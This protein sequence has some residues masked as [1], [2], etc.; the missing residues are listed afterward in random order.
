[1]QDLSNKIVHGL[2]PN[3]PVTIIGVK[4]LG[5]KISLRYTG[6]NSGKRSSKVLSPEEYERLEVITE[7]GEF[8]FKGNAEHFKLFVE[9]ERIHTAYQFDPLFA[10]NCSVVDPLPHQVEAVYQNLLP[11]PRIRFLLADDTGAGKTIMAGLLIKEL[12]IRSLVERILIITPGGLTKQWQQD[13]MQLKFNMSFR[14]VDRATFNSEPNIFTTADRLVTSID[15][16]RGEDVINVAKET[17]WDM[18]IVDEAHKLSAYNYGNRSYKSQRY[19]TIEALAGQCEHLLLLTATPHRGRKD[20]FKNLLQLLD[21]DIFASDVLVTDRINELSKTGANKFFIRRLKEEMKDWEGAPLFKKRYTKTTAYKLTTPEM[22]L[23]DAVTNYLTRRKEEADQNRNVH[24]TLTLMVMQRRLTSSI[25][26][27]MRTLHKR[28]EALKGV[29]EIIHANPKLWTQRHKFE[30]VEINDIDDYDEL[31]DEERQQLEDVL[32]D[33]KKFKLFTTANNA[34]EI[35]E[36]ADE[37]KVLYEMAKGLYESNTEEQKLKVLRELLTSQDVVDNDKKL[38][39]FTE[40]KDTLDYLEDQLGK[41][42][43]LTIATIHGGKSVDERRAAQDAFREDAQILLATDAAGEGINLQFCTQLLNWDIPWN[44]NRLEQRMGRIHRYGQKEDVIVFNMVAQNTR[45]GAVLERLLVKLDVIREQLGDDRV[46]DVISDVME[47]MDLSKIKEA[48]FDGRQ[49]EFTDLLD[50]SPEQTAELFQQKIEEQETRLG[51]STVNYASART[52]KEKSD[53]RRLTPIYVR[54]FFESAFHNLGGNIN[55]VAPGIYQIV[56]FPRPV[57]QLLRREYNMNA[58]AKNINYCFDK[59]IFREAEHGSRYGKLHYISP[60]NPIFDSVLRVIREQYREEAL[61]GTILIS[62][63]EKEPYFAYL[64]RSS[65][66]DNRSEQSE[67][68]ADAQSAFVAQKETGDFSSTSPAKFLNLFPPN[69]LA[70]QPEVP[71]PMTNDK[72]MAWAFEHITEPQFEAVERRTQDDT[73]ERRLYLEEAFSNLQFDLIAEINDLQGDLLQGKRNT[74]EKLQRKEEA[75][76]R[77]LVKRAERLLK[78]DQMTE[79]SVREPEVLACAYVVPLTEVQFES[80]FGMKRDDEVERIAMEFAMAYERE[81]GR[82]PEDVG[83][84]NLGYDVSSTDADGLKRYIEVKGRA[85]DEDRVMLT[86]NEKARLSQLGNKAWLYIVLKCKRGNPEL[87]RIQDPGRVLR[88]EKISKGV[89]Y[90]L[91]RDEWTA[92]LCENE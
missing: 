89:Q 74:D 70:I 57:E 45:E 26:A 62:A 88:F 77:L 37:V 40:H 80:N 51:H 60:G 68:I 39:I 24:V 18:I 44:P 61:K 41:R 5:S 91:L 25:Y 84:Q 49:N 4:P 22:R 85:G 14:L 12:M 35:R 59:T 23:Y 2:E 90:L 81:H 69:N 34:Q 50:A 6:N 42:G 58:E 7:E 55:E 86:E 56:Q 87:F 16:L 73:Q 63:D 46:Y 20:T 27:I 82:T 17:R 72:V 67:S 10:V 15:F 11:L 31:S 13:E 75:M 83:A 64:V 78:L 32:S 36:E 66:T 53:E 76:N 21:E 52:L 47:G 28:H 38:V 8:N 30:T 65:I 9:A 33:S 3:E 79:L 54:D 19:S 29:L 1:M 92:H 71:E 48:V 43:G